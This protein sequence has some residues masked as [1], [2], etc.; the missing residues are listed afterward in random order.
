MIRKNEE[1]I[2]ED[3]LARENLKHSEQRKE[4]LD[5]FLNTDKHITADELYGIVRKKYPSIGY[6][7]IYRT[8][9]LL[10]ECGLCLE[11]KIDDGTTRYEHLYGHR[12]HDHLICVKCNRFVEVVDPDIERLQEK[13]FKRFGFAPQRHRMELYGICKKCKK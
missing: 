3:Y 2:F 6:A 10:C 7:T 5:V 13:L 12:H 11:L 9:R 8:I 4:I 1:K